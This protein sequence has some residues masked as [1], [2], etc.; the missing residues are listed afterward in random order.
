M[1]CNRPVIIGGKE[2]LC[3]AYAKTKRH[4]VTQSRFGKSDYTSDCQERTITRTK[5]R[6]LSIKKRYFVTL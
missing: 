5:A 6:V 1:W 2:V 4:A 3:P